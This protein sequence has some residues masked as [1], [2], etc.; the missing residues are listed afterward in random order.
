MSYLQAIET[1][2]FRFKVHVTTINHAN[3]WEKINKTSYYTG[4]GIKMILIL[5]V[6]SEHFIHQL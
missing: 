3:I 6:G 4:T 1:D 5:Q 2:L